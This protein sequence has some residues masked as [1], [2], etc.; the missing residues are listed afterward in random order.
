MQSAKDISPEQQAAFDQALTEEAMGRLD[1]GVGEI[2]VPEV[3]GARCAAL[4]IEGVSSFAAL[5][6]EMDRL[7]ALG[8]RNGVK[9][10]MIHG[11]FSFD[12][13]ESQQ[14]TRAEKMQAAREA[15]VE[16][17]LGEHAKYL[18][19]HIDKAHHHIHAAVAAVHP[20]TLL[21]WE[22]NRD[23]F[24]ISLACR[25]VEIAHGYKHDNGLYMA[26][27]HPGQAT[28]IELRTQREAMAHKAER[29]QDRLEERVR[30]TLGDYATFETAHTWRETVVARLHEHAEKYQAAGMEAFWA[31]AHLLAAEWNGRLRKDEEGA[32][33]LDLWERIPEAEVVPR[34]IID[35]HG[36]DVEI[37]GLTMRPTGISLPIARDD[38]PF[39]GE[40]LDFDAAETDFEQRVR[41]D[42][43][44]VGRVLTDV[45]GRGM[46]S[47]SDVDAFVHR[48]HSD[49]VIATDISDEVIERDKTIAMVAVDAARPMYVRHDQQ[50]LEQR[51][52]DRG[53]RMAVPDARFTE[54]AYERALAG[55]E[56]RAGYRLTAEQRDLVHS[57]GANRFAWAD[58][59]AGSGKT[60][61]M[62][63]TKAL[64]DDLGAPIVGVATSKA[65]AMKLQAE[66]GIPCYT[67]KRATMGR[68]VI[69][70]GAWVI[71]DES[72][73]SSY[74]ALDAIG[75]L[76]ERTGGKMA[77]IGG[78]A[79][80]ASIEGGAPHDV[81]C[82]VA[83]EHG[84]FSELREVWRQKGGPLAFLASNP[85]AATEEER[86]GLIARVEEA[87]RAGD[88]QGVERFVHALDA[89]GLIETCD[90]RDHVI[91]AA[92]A[93]YVRDAD[94][95]LLACKD[96]ETVKHTNQTIF[97]NLGLTG[98]GHE[99][100][101]GRSGRETRELA[102]GGRVQF[103]RN[104]LPG[105]IQGG[106]VANN[107]LGTVRAM[108][109]RDGRWK[110]EVEV[111]GLKG[112]APRVISFDPQVYKYV[113]HGY[114]I[115]S[116]KSQGQEA[117]RAGWIW[118]KTSDANMA[119]VNVSRAT[120][121]A[122]GFSSK[123]DFQSVD[124]LAKHLGG[125]I[126][127]KDDVQ[128]LR[129]TIEKTGGKDTVWAR[130]VLEALQRLN[131]PLR[132]QY[133]RE[134]QA[135]D[136]T[137]RARAADLQAKTNALRADASTPAERRA[138]TKWHTEQARK[139]A[140]ALKRH[141]TFSEWC[142]SNKARLEG[143]AIQQGAQPT[144]ALSLVGQLRAEARAVD[145]QIRRDRIEAAE[146][147]QREL[148]ARNLTIARA[149]CVPIAGTKAAEYLA[150]RG[151]RVAGNVAH[152]APNW[153][154]G[155]VNDAG[156]V[157]KGL[158]P[159][160]VFEFR[161]AAGDCVAAQGRFV[162][163]PVFDG[164]A[165][166]MWTVGALGESVFWTPGAR[167]AE[168]LA[169]CEA[170]IDAL[171]LVACGLP[172]IALGGTQNQPTFLADVLAGRTVVLALDD[173]VPG[174]A[175]AVKLETL[176]QRS[177]T[178]RLVLPPGIKGAHLKDVNEALTRVPDALR[179]AVQAAKARVGI[180]QSEIEEPQ[181]RVSE[182]E[183][184][185]GR[186][187]DVGG[188]SR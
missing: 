102:V 47:R 177:Q 79:Q 149:A 131:H 41:A 30:R 156:K 101:L 158:G 26:R 110:I 186:G 58:G 7:G 92:A 118:D 147:A 105:Q 71:V 163:P 2:W 143:E 10:P 18:T 134:C 4:L 124:D 51:V 3:G 49:V 112:A 33:H 6:S 127:L 132:Q 28:T 188:M 179:Y 155:V 168:T 80:L 115:T 23:R 126:V 176:L 114:C 153:P 130:N 25:K 187:R 173:D 74:K 138:A 45:E 69:K 81:L 108:T 82:D 116:T 142:V 136:D 141:P 8:V 43:T 151:L 159:A 87:I 29:Q 157:A 161:T 9:E 85:A 61:S 178:T 106:S 167:E 97:A 60:T 16:M 146:A 135:Q 22:R 72:S 19:L 34:Y 27:E 21:A 31:D 172:A 170:P 55:F 107:E 56:A 83:R 150:G 145:E 98:T 88:E 94:G 122:R 104:S 14:L 12:P 77:G 86:V 109:E 35:E 46:W 52:V 68:P 169:V 73:M 48:R 11:V 42:P 76:V 63:A 57:I 183:K 54:D 37:P 175:A 139:L 15:L 148:H 137:Y 140:G 171:S 59:A 75:A 39:A 180:E 160:V 53:A 164:K 65:A 174:I 103:L 67:L 181:R 144:R 120:Q 152:F 64:A 89:H 123:Q 90:D 20:E 62:R 162:D 154:E 166:K 24:R 95:A 84:S 119:L 121:E 13:I 111:D 96:R 182:R 5:E 78:S 165:F 117:R 184:K 93:W 133:A 17:G 38:L 91:A 99:F 113:E 40:F 129:R 66:T 36:E 32:V 100:R 125:N 128:L 50:A 1:M 185:I 44:I 70:P